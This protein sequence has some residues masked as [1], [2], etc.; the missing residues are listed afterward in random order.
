[1]KKDN[2]LMVIISIIL[3]LVIASAIFAYLKKTKMQKYHDS[4]TKVINFSNLKK[5]VIL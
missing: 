2:K 1:M 4:K 5:I 3:T